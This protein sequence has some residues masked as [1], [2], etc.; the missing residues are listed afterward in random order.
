M[1]T[2]H[3]M[4]LLTLATIALG[5]AA[6]PATQDPTPNA[7]SPAGS[8]DAAVTTLKVETRVVAI[9]AVVTGK[10]GRPL[11][12]LTKDDFVLRQDGQEKP[13]R[14]FSQ[15]SE[16]PLTI[17]LMVDTSG[18]QRTYIG[19]ETLASDVFFETMLG[20]RE[21]RAMLVQFDSHVL[22]LHSL[23][24]SANA[25][26]LG[27]LGLRPDP[28]T[29]G[30]TLLQDAV[31]AVSKSILA[32]E[33]GRKAM[34]ILTD[35]GDNGSRKSLAE[36]IE[37]AQRADVQVYSILYSAWESGGP[38]ALG[39]GLNGLRPAGPDP[40]LKLLEQLSESTGGRVFRVSRTLGLR[41]I[42][43]DIA[44]DLRLQYEIGYTPPPDI[45]PN[46]YHRLELKAKDK[47]LIVQA[48]H[49]FFAQP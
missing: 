7:S 19:D 42:Y 22:Q 5:R 38:V 20:R 40:G 10:D 13:I 16:L 34:V 48:R 11:G 14:Y 32:K 47:K 8:Q 45:Q 49:G 4:C 18:S 36:A 31:Y 37:Q 29:P 17:A 44:Q 24:S 23:T 35:G 28:T 1:T 39:T 46:S 43:A 9:S 27:L 15:G 6:A 25:L 33:T 30:G 3:A 12:G 21:D 26:H 41:Q 2:A